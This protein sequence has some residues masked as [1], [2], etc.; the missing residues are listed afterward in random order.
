MSSFAD[1]LKSLREGQN[2]TQAQLGEEM[3]LSL[4]TILRWEKGKAEPSLSDIKKLAGF[5]NVSVSQLLGE[6]GETNRPS[7][8]SAEDL[9]QI[10]KDLAAENP[11]IVIRFRNMRQQ[12]SE[13]SSAEKRVILDGMMYVLGKADVEVQSR[14]RREGKKGNV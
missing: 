7:T 10:M 14:L 11:D 9:D 5:F 4:H 8:E 1:I 13:L 6:D 2:L 12:W 3:G